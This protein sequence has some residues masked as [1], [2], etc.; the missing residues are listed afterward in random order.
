V[1]DKGA[2]VT[3]HIS[4]RYRELPPPR[5]FSGRLVCM[6]TQTIE[7]TEGNYRHSVLPDG[8]VDIVWIGRAE[9]IIAGPATHRIVVG[10]P[11]GTSLIGARFR[12][13][14]AASCLGLPVDELLNQDVPLA[15]IWGHDV[16]RFTEQ[17]HQHHSLAAKLRGVAAALMIRLANAADADPQVRIAIPW[18][19]R[20]PSGRVRDLVR[21]IGL[22]E[23]QFQRRFRAAVG[24]GPK[25]FQR[26][27]RFQRL[28]AL[29]P[30]TASERLNLAASASDA[31]YA[32]QAHMCREVRALAGGSPQTILGNVD[33]TLSMSDLFNTEA[34]ASDYT[35]QIENPVDEEDLWNNE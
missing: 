8:C 13:G 12:P 30:N 25:T 4:S 11:A 26:I 15:E 33:T 1:N 14:W 2:T 21:L 10:L 20:H 29:S 19:V 5:S 22:S 6:W 27:V 24:Y 3:S 23:R 34:C 31:G 9:P 17:I 32:D 7:G 16:E 35:W 28:L 18:L